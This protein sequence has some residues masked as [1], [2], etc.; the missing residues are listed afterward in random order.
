MAEF[1]GN[2]EY[3]L[4]W[5]VYVLAGLGCCAIWW[6]M[7]RFIGHR[8]WRELLRGVVVVLIF[9][10]WYVGDSPEFY[11]PAIVVLLM[12]LLLEGAKAGLN[13]GI[14][15]LISSFLM[16]CILTGRIIL[17]RKPRQG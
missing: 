13:G 8:G 11:A 6:R 5:S 3:V 7:T 4:A 1:F 9:T 10:P 14:A 12:D 16:L 17:S 15:L 2:Y